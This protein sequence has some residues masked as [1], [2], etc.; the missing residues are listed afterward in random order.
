MLKVPS[1]EQ[2]QAKRDAERFYRRAYMSMGAEALAGSEEI[3]AFYAADAE[4]YLSLFI[5]A[6]DAAGMP[7]SWLPHV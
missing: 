7:A 3:R 6:R 2:A 4:K 5:G 1:I